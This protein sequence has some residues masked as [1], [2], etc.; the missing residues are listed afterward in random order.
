[1][2]K[3]L[4]L[5]NLARNQNIISNSVY[6]IYY[7]DSCKVTKMCMLL[8]KCSIFSMIIIIPLVLKRLSMTSDV[9]TEC[10]NLKILCAFLLDNHYNNI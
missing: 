2:Y 10:F 8:Y 1:M 7:I 9:L 6:T 5:Q 4:H 3:N